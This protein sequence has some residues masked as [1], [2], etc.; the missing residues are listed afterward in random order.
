LSADERTAYTVSKDGTILRWDLETMKRTQLVRC[1]A[2]RG[3]GG[4]H[5]P[6]LRGGGWAE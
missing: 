4:L 2:G 3:G 6:A 5:R 1:A